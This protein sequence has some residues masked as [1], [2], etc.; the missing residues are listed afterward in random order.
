MLLQ[1]LTREIRDRL[2]SITKKILEHYFNLM[3]LYRDKTNYRDYD[4]N[5]FTLPLV[6]DLK[7]WYVPF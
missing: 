7:K 5:D 2:Y 3:K 1:K 4:C 6:D